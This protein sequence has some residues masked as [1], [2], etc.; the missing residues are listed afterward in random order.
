MT[1]FW[2][3]HEVVASFDLA[4]RR[5][6]ELTVAEAAR[7]AGLTAWV[8]IQIVTRYARNSRGGT[9]KRQERVPLCRGYV[10]IDEPARHIRGVRG[11]LSIDTAVGEQPFPIPHAQFAG[12]V[13][14]D[15]S[16]VE[17]GDKPRV[18]TIGQIVRVAG[19][20]QPVT[21]TKFTRGGRV[22][23][24]VPMLGGARPVQVR[25]SQIVA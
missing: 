25:D 5:A 4:A 16:T 10:F 20:D 1:D 23:V 2:F 21:I 3:A 8:P 9:T 17:T 18:L 22:I 12:L 24:D 14:L 19:L 11:V 15:G 6:N 7:D 13:A